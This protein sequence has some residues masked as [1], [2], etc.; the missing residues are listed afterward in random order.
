MQS[1]GRSLQMDNGALVIDVSDAG[2]A[3]SGSLNESGSP[4]QERYQTGAVGHQGDE[5]V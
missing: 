2:E 5:S 3:R 4:S 1:R